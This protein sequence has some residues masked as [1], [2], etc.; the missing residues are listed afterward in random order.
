MASPVHYWTKLTESTLVQTASI[1]GRTISE[2]DSYYE[3]LKSVCTV[4]QKK[5]SSFS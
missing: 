2:I 5:K 3:A 1:Y 4:F